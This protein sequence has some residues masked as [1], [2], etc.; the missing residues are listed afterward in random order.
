MVVVRGNEALCAFYRESGDIARKLSEQL[1]AASLGEQLQFSSMWG[2]TCMRKRDRVGKQ[3]KQWH[4]N[5][6]SILPTTIISPG[7]LVSS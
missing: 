2:V 3:N 4:S 1:V 7:Y 6:L 5:R